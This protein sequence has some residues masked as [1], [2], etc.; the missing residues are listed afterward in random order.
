VCGSDDTSGGNLYRDA[1]YETSR[2]SCGHPVVVQKERVAKKTVSHSGN[3]FQERNINLSIC[4]VTLFITSSS[5]FPIKHSKLI[6][7]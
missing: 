1:C 5:G 7:R 6:S 4:N 3:T 2:T